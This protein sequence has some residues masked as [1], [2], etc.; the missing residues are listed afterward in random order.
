MKLIPLTYGY[1]AQV[2]NQDYSL[3]KK[4]HWHLVRSYKTLYART[5]VKEKKLKILMHNFF[6]YENIN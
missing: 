5:W 3:V 6:K 2:S 4:Y 1:Y